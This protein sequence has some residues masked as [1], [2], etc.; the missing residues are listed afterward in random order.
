MKQTA[1]DFLQWN[2]PVQRNMIAGKLSA[3]KDVSAGPPGKFPGDL[4]Q[5]PIVLK[6]IYG[7]I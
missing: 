3:Q 1:A 5:I 4:F 6:K 7:M 2:L